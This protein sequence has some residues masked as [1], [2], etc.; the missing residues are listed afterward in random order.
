MSEASPFD[1]VPD[2]CSEFDFWSWAGA[3]PRL[4]LSTRT[5]FAKF[6]RT[7][8]CVRERGP[9]AS[10]T[11]L[12]PLPAPD[13]TVFE[14]GSLPHL[15]AGEVLSQA[16]KEVLVSRVLHV[17]VMALNFLHA[18][19]RHVPV[20]SLQ[21]EASD[22]QERIFSRLRGLI[23]VCS[24]QGVHSLASGRRGTHLI[25]RLRELTLHLSSLGLSTFP[26]P[27]SDSVSGF[28]PHAEGGP[29]V[30]NPY[31]DVDP[32][33]LKISGDGSWPLEKY[34]GPELRL[35]YLEPGVLR[36]IPLNQLPYPAAEK[37]DPL[38]GAAPPL[39]F[40]RPPLLVFP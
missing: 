1:G 5:S 40:Q 16:A 4:I 30:L 26:Y 15:P 11:A 27:R 33:R 2:F 38:P 17:V 24:E 22:G 14:R 19:C 37:E 3:L 29:E 9:R 20:A 36:E 31:R 10:D 25:A 35:A 7:S 6:L 23:W 39:G 21:R 12:F 32:G 34:L 13:A 28:L 18:D 8:F